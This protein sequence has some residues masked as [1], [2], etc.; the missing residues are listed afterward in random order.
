MIKL[1]GLDLRCG[2]VIIQFHFKIFVGAALTCFQKLCNSS[3]NSIRLA[4]E[5][6]RARRLCISTFCYQFW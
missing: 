3:L 5:G 2:Y 6:E 1:S 4:S